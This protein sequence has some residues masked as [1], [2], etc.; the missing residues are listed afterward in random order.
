MIAKFI[1]EDNIKLSK[2]KKTNLLQDYQNKGFV[3]L[4]EGT[5]VKSIKE[6]AAEQEEY[7][8]VII[9]GKLQ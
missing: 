9:I 4:P 7:T 6:L 3:T 1:L 8:V 5:I 2:Y